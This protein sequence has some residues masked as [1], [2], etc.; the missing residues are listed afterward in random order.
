V[1]RWKQRSGAWP[2]PRQSL[3]RQLG[4]AQTATDV[5]QPQ[6]QQLLLGSVSPFPADC[7]GLVARALESAEGSRSPALR[8]ALDDACEWVRA[9]AVLLRRRCVQWSGAT[10]SPSLVDSLGRG[11]LS[12]AAALAPA[13][14]DAAAPAALRSALGLPASAG[15][16]VAAGAHALFIAAC[17]A[18]PCRRRRV[19]TCGGSRTRAPAVGAMGSLSRAPIPGAAPRAPAA[20]GAGAGALRRVVLLEVPAASRLPPCFGPA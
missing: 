3:H 9:L 2:A 10:S 4:L 11:L 13:A 6:P 7:L 14:V 12:L 20:A 19:F 1:R 18:V 17:D 16:P 5:Q 8:Q 15:V